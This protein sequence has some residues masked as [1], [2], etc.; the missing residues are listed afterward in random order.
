MNALP[1]SSTWH[2]LPAW[3]KFLDQLGSL[4]ASGARVRRGGEIKRIDAVERMP[5][6]VLL[7]EAGK[8]IPADARAL[9]AHSAE[10][11]E[12]VLTGESHAVVKSPAAADESRRWRNGDV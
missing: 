3:L 11:A 2:A 6:N 5:G 9:H 8:R 7:L 4:P 12:A 1:A 10:V